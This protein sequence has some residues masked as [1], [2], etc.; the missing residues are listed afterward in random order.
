M[1]DYDYHQPNILF[2][3]HC[4]HAATPPTI[5]IEQYDSIPPFASTESWNSSNLKCWWC[6]CTFDTKPVFIPSYL[7]ANC[8]GTMGNFCSF[9]CAQGYIEQNFRGNQ[10]WEKTELLKVLY[11]RFTNESIQEIIAAPDKTVMTQYGGM[12]TPQEF[13]AK[14]KLLNTSQRTFIHNNQ[15]YHLTIK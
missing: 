1:M 12:V 4:S 15:F 3:K 13:A 7:E 8:A 2:L 14:I 10:K 11:K 9:N 6:D 5:K